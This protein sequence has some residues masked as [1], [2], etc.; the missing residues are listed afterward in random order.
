L[1]KEFLMKKNTG[2]LKAAGR[3][4]A[5]GLAALVLTALAG[6]PVTAAGEE[7][8]TQKSAVLLAEDTWADGA[9]SS[10]S[11]EQ[12]FKFTATAG[13]QYLHV[14]FGTMTSMYV[15]LYDSSNDALGSERT[16]SGSSG[17]Y[18]NLALTVVSGKSYYVKVA[19]G[20]SWAGSPTGT[21]KIGF[22]TMPLPC[23]TLAGAAAL[24]ADT[25]A[26][27]ALNTS[28]S[29]QWFKFTAAAGT[30]YLHVFF[31]TLTDMGVQLH[32]GGGGTLG[33]SMHLYS[34]TT[35]KSLIVTSGQT[36]YIKVTPYYSN[37]GGGTYRIAF[38]SSDTAPASL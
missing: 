15:Q 10:T 35:S 33:S 11:G 13:T 16:L 6:C 36:Y 3:A 5:L 14:M 28:G 26:V 2:F 7:G 18:E 34:S 38:N 30:H 8:E 31:G 19:K 24:T 9:V 17:G 21:Y 22:N 27:G 12:W 20:P 23:G 25:W 1:F 32:D 29:E 4:A 37:S